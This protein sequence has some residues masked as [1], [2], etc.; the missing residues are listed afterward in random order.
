MNMP[1]T[2]RD[3]A[4]LKSGPGLYAFDALPNTLKALMAFIAEDYL[5]EITAH[6]EFANEWLTRQDA[7]QLEPGA[8][9]A[10]NWNGEI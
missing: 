5:P 10:W 4:A 9:R 1:E 6:I 7:P 8:A 2:F 3:E